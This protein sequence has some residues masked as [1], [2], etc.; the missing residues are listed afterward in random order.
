[1][2]HPDKH[3][4][5][6]NDAQM[7]YIESGTGDPVVFLHGNPTS[8]YLWR[9]VIPEVTGQGRCLAPDLI[10]MGDSD[11]LPD[12]GP[13]SYTFAQ[14]RDYLDGWFEVVHATANVTLVGHDWG[15]ALAFDWARRHPDAVHGIVYMEA[16]VAAGRWT[17][18]P[19]P[20]A[21]LFRAL[22]SPAGE[23]MILEQNLFVEQI[24]PAG[25][26]EPLSKQTL[27]EYR[28][29]YLAA[30]EDRRPTLTWPREIPLDGDPPD[31][32]QTIREYGAWLAS[33]PVPKLFINA[34]PGQVLTGNPRELCRTWP[35]QTEV[36]LP[37]RHFI[38]E[39]SGPQVGQA[40]A[41]WLEHLS[42]DACE[43]TYAE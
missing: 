9:R 2:T 25:V 16:P 7:A 41:R 29:P 10:G 35:N 27:A 19:P 18:F 23:A 37:G 28:R 39:D 21:E 24:L 5:T 4:V 13:G 12:S 20:A 26:L 15:A 8:S 1:M 36:T 17:D 6:V 32:A 42:G 30:G 38:Q 33:T 31:V 11:K 40:I 34:E 3:H 22:R 43:A 14:H